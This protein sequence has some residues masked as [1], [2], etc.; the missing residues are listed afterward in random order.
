MTTLSASPRT[1]TATTPRRRSRL[2]RIAS[3]ARSEVKLLT[4]NSTILATA[5]LLGPA[6]AL[7]MSQLSAMQG[8]LDERFSAVAVNLLITWCVL[9]AVYYNLTSILV[10]RREEGVLKRM[11]TGEISP[12]DAIVA[13]AIPSVGVFLVQV[14]LGT[15]LVLAVI[16]V[17]ALPNPL[18]IVIGML[19]AAV[20]CV[21]LSAV[22]TSF[23]TS[24]EAA[25][26]STM[27]IFLALIFLS[28]TSFSLATMPEA[29]QTI[30]SFTPLNAVGELVSLG[31]TGTTL[32]G[33]ATEGFL[34]TSAF[35]IRPLLVLA[36]WIGFAWMLA[37]R[38]MRFEP[39][40]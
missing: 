38:S 8:P 32:L 15:A 24:V 18:L 7:I 28:G 11:T 29:L 34:G 37:R 27:P 21:L 36:A 9:M 30:A 17:P 2:G 33:D 16:G 23:T 40:R 14:V 26:Y 12:W 10:A 3:L 19:G 25:Q 13:A 20:V 35:A 5:L 4:R 22:S 6:M 31:A 39:R 1:T